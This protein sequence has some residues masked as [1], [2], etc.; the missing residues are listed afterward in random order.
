MNT[1]TTIRWR[2]RILGAL[3]GFALATGVLEGA[4]FLY[5]PGDLILTFR[6]DGN[7]QDYVV[8]L[9]KTT[10][11]NAL[12]AGTS[13]PIAQLSERMENTHR[14]GRGLGVGD[15]AECWNPIKSRRRTMGRNLR[16][17]N[18]D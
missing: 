2:A 1:Q 5:S 17:S 4:P 6:Q 14:F 13:V 16:D 7:A 11:Y 12:P 15:R 8:N 18:L 9:G 10:N 3:G